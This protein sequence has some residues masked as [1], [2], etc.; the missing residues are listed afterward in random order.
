MW[1]SIYLYRRCKVVRNQPKL[2][3]SIFYLYLFGTV[4][5]DTSWNWVAVLISTSPSPKPNYSTACLFASKKHGK[6][7]KNL[8]WLG[9]SSERL[10]HFQLMLIEPDEVSK[11][12][13]NGVKFPKN[14]FHS[15]GLTIDLEIINMVLVSWNASGYIL[16]LTL[17]AVSI[18]TLF[19]W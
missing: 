8:K 16:Y 9:I 10:W 12:A 13:T 5:L 18:E 11:I 7:R 3:F 17:V 15:R 4:L 6:G 19:L 2:Q 1:I 14:Y